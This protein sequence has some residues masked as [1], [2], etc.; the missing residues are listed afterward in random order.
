[1][2]LKK[3]LPTNHHQNVIQFNKIQKT[4][5]QINVHFLKIYIFNCVCHSK[6]FKNEVIFSIWKNIDKMWNIEIDVYV[7][8]KVQYGL[9]IMQSTIFSHQV[10]WFD[11]KI[12]NSMFAICTLT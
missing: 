3:K 5:I 4:F 7:M 1:M 8:F 2:G 11:F 9:N 12:V 10:E 6:Y